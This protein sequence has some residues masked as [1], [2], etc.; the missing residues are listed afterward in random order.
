MKASHIRENILTESEMKSREFAVDK[1]T[2][3]HGFGKELFL[4][5][6]RDLDDVTL[7]YR[8]TKNAEKSER[9]Q[10]YFLLISQHSSDKGTINVPVYINEHGLYN[11][12]EIDTNKIG[13]V[14]GRD[15]LKSFLE[16]EVRKGNLVRIRKRS[17]P[18]S[19]LTV[20]KVTV[21][22][23]VAT[24]RGGS[25]VSEKPTTKADNYYDITPE[26]FADYK[27]ALRS[28]RLIPNLQDVAELK[29]MFGTFGAAYRQYGRKL[30]M[31]AKGTENAFYI[32]EVW[33]ELCDSV[34]LL[35]RDAESTQDMWRNLIEV[36]DSL[37]EKNGFNPYITDGDL[38]ANEAAGALGA[39]ILERFN[40]VRADTTFADRAQ[41]RIDL[42]FPIVVMRVKIFSLTGCSD[43]I[44][45]SLNRTLSRNSLT[46]RPHTLSFH[47]I[48]SS[49]NK[50]A[51][52]SA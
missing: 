49:A 44:N 31:R 52:S 36:R 3:Y 21:S 19:V 17:S 46:A 4:D 26:E 40:E 47:T 30:N 32:D 18:V 16:Q 10:N 23:N 1:H 48:L 11:R 25:E 28:Y 37:D 29:D 12:V 45:P 33:D 22:N 34:P 2:Y 24:S 43:I 15:N 6:I 7:A 8:G 20:D 27:K 14:F 13:T 41:Q 42:R 35:N 9:R 50:C 51:N 38:T 39:D 5:V